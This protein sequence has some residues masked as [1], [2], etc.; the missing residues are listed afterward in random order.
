MKKRL[1]DSDL[2]EGPS[3]LP[4]AHVERTQQLGIVDSAIAL[5]DGPTVDVI[6]S[7]V[8]LPIK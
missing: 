1:S 7:C 4:T 3:A 8:A 6:S 5:Q 2:Q